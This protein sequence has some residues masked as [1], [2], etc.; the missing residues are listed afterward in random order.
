MSEIEKDRDDI[1]QIRRNLN[2]HLNGHKL[3]E[4][5][6]IDYNEHLIYKL[7]AKKIDKNVNDSKQTLEE[8][9]RD[10]HNALNFHHQE[11][12]NELTETGKLI[13][14]S[15]QRLGKYIQIV[16]CLIPEETEDIWEASSQY[17]EG[18]KRQL[19][20]WQEKFKNK[21]STDLNNF[22]NKTI[23]FKNEGEQVMS[24]LTRMDTLVQKRVEDIAKDVEDIAKK[25]NEMRK[26][27]EDIAKDQNK[28]RKEMMTLYKKMHNDVRTIKE[29]LKGTERTTA[30]SSN[31]IPSQDARKQDKAF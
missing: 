4:Q 8:M 2:Q 27:V 13:Q 31:H 18:L 11:L 19:E 25:Q 15:L 10:K 17:M 1:Q 7:F 12:T 5:Q 9:T 14:N 22:K 29:E 24:N 30:S 28:M 21:I 20:Q 23:Q 16:Q 3:D 6:K 26:D